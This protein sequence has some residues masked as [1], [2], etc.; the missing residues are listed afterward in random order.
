MI[1]QTLVKTH[2]KPDIEGDRK[3]HTD[4]QMLSRQLAIHTQLERKAKQTRR[5][6]C[7]CYCKRKG[8]REKERGRKKGREPG[9]ERERAP[10]TGEW[11]T[12]NHFPRYSSLSPHEKAALTCP[13]CQALEGESLSWF[14]SHSHRH[15]QSTPR[16]AAPDRDAA[17]CFASPDPPMDSPAAK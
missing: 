2:T 12:D 8:Q 16:P 3:V 13:S 1:L 6:F 4:R 9:R 15:N 11:D 17:T 10:H 14:H 7:P 5:D